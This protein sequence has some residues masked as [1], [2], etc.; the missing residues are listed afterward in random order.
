MVA[1]Q[2]RHSFLLAV[3]ATYALIFSSLHT[4]GEAFTSSSQVQETKSLIAESNRLFYIPF[5]AFSIGKVEK[6][7]N[8]SGKL[9]HYTDNGFSSSSFPNLYKTQEGRQNWYIFIP[10]LH[11]IMPQAP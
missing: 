4:S 11:G 8:D 10:H 2:L 7:T 9:I 1:H 3:L 5:H 6:V